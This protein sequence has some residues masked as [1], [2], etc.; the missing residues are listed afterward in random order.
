MILLALA[1][2]GLV[3][4]TLMTASQLIHL[5]P[6]GRVVLPPGEELMVSVLKPL[7]GADPGL[8]DNIRSFFD[9]SYA[10][11]ELLFGVQDPADP[12]VP[13]VRK[14]IREHPEVSARIVISRRRLGLN[15]KVNNLA[16][17]LEAARG[18]VIL[19]SDSNVRVRPDYLGGLVAELRKPCVR[20]VSSPFRGIG[21]GSLGA[22]L[23]SLQLNTYVLGGTT[24]VHRL[25][26]GVCVVGKSMMLRR[27][28]LEAIGG[29][30]F[31]SRFLA[32]DQVCGE[33]IARLGGKLSLAPAVVDN[34]VGR[35]SIG[36]FLSRHLRWASIRWR[37][38]P[39]G[40]LGEILLSPSALALAVVASEPGLRSLGAF[41]LILAA[42]SVLAGLS[43][44]RLGIRRSILLYPP[45]LLLKDLL[46]TL[47]WPLAIFQSKI[48]WRGAEYRICRR[49]FL[50]AAETP[51][52]MSRVFQ[53]LSALR[54]A[55]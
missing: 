27:V 9:Q 12:A 43:E 1:T 31:L 10:K 35:P 40:Y 46:L 39:I 38:A 34:I 19:I 51:R 24:A 33:E 47:A 44:R 5:R 41:G 8:E 49:T 25:W 3:A 16:N 50:K 54:K 28:D 52:G 53:R 36:D 21:R 23:E 13:V 45:L 30:R 22:T 17:I 2:L 6:H 7:K 42:Q 15:P 4:L 48:T 18:D 55:A 20:L 32:E 29:F 11:Y 14:V 26:G 37:I